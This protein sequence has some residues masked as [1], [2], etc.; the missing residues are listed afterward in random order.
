MASTSGPGPGSCTTTGIG[1]LA[2]ARAS[3]AALPWAEGGAG[4][5]ATWPSRLVRAVTS[6]SAKPRTVAILCSTVEAY[7]GASQASCATWL[8]ITI[9]STIDDA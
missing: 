7:C 5:C 3:A 6:P 4:V 2:A 8:P 1:C 9:P